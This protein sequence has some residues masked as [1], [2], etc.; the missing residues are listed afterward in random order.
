MT[1]NPGS[2]RQFFK[3]A[4][5]QPGDEQEGAWPRARL[6]AMNRHFCESVERA[7][8]SGKEQR[9]AAAEVEERRD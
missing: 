7:I 6:V 9:P 2:W 4:P 5:N 8:A 3:D 1:S